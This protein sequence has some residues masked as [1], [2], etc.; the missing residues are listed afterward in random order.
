MF[1]TTIIVTPTSTFIDFRR[2]LH[3][4]CQYHLVPLYFCIQYLEFLNGSYNSVNK[5]SANEIEVDGKY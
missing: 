2:R 3:H 1:V 4:D 5:V